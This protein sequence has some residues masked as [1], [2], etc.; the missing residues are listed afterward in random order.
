MDGAN[1]H[2]GQ[3]EY[4]EPLRINE[5]KQLNLSGGWDSS[6]IDHAGESRVA[7]MEIKRGTV[8]VKGLHLGQ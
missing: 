4:G 8:K 5:H 7:S 6:F 2:I 1:I 3:G